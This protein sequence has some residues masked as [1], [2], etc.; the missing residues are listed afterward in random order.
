MST[1]YNRPLRS[2]ELYHYGRS[3]RDGAPI[4]SGRPKKGEVR[5]F[6]AEQKKRIVQ[7]K[8][9]LSRAKEARR[10]N[11]GSAKEARNVARK[12][13]R[14]AHNHVGDDIDAYSY[15]YKVDKNEV[16]K[17]IAEDRK[18]KEA[19][20]QA[21]ANLKN[22][23]IASSQEIKQIKGEIADARNQRRNAE[24]ILYQRK[25]QEHDP[26]YL[27][28]NSHKYTADQLNEKLKHIEAEQKLHQAAL[29][30]AERGKKAADIVIGYGDS[31][32]KAIKTV[33]DINKNLKDWDGTIGGLDITN[34]RKYKHSDRFKHQR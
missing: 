11:V 25:T 34:R 33:N 22:T 4:G 8:A 5:A 13:Y 10:V 30:K 23:K 9:D 28:A 29:D 24:K 21:K 15:G 12:N 27:L 3:K 17:H 19:Y 20:K 32:K 31:A 26:S 16:K 6:R 2:D 14:D 1:F 18:T 7:G